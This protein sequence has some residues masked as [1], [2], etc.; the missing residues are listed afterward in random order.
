MR[1]RTKLPRA[2]DRFEA[3]ILAGVRMQSLETEYVIFYFN[4]WNLLFQVTSD[5]I[6]IFH[7]R[8]CLKNRRPSAEVGIITGV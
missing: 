8:L 1:E 7:S 6:N 2:F 5:F 4:S 3:N